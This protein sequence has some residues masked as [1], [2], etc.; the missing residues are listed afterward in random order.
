MT[1]FFLQGNIVF[2]QPSYS[3]FI[4]FRLL[5]E[6]GEPVSMRH[7]N[8]EFSIVNSFGVVIKADSN[9]RATNYLW[10]DHRS[11]YFTY[12]IVYTHREYFFALYHDDSLMQIAV[13][14]NEAQPQK[15]LAIDIPFSPGEFLLDFDLDNRKTRKHLKTIEDSVFVDQTFYVIHSADWDKLEQKFDQSEYAKSSYIFEHFLKNQHYAD[16]SLIGNTFSAMTSESCAEMLGGGCMKYGYTYV[17]FEQD[18]V[19]M[20]FALKMD[21]SVNDSSYSEYT[22]PSLAQKYFWYADGDIIHVVGQDRFQFRIQNGKLYGNDL[23]RERFGDKPKTFRFII[24]VG[25]Q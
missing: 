17:T 18:S 23:R 6:N 13:P 8:Q 25:K 14:I 20:Y 4:K 3:T 19:T 22:Q 5:D 12:H 16:S 7:F 1:V 21:C 10:Y 24:A 11:R 15:L 2:A 9:L